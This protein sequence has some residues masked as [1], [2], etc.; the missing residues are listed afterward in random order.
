[1]RVLA[2]AA[3]SGFLV[4]APYATT[5]AGASPQSWA[6]VQSPNQDHGAR[7]AAPGALSP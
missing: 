4:V 5:A 6:P 2:A 7:A 3:L 1:M